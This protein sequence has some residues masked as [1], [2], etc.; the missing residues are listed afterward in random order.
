MS[1]LI[2]AEEAGDSLTEMELFATCTLLLTAGH[3]TTINL[4]GNGTLAL[5]R[6]PAQLEQLKANPGLM[7]TAVEELLRYDS[8]VQMT[9]RHIMADFEYCGQTVQAGAADELH[10]RG[11]QP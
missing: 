10:V 2:M 11:G 5:L 6:H 9:A 1:A 4:I 7:K 8:P 3:E